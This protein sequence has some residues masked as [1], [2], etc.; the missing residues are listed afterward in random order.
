MYATGRDQDNF[1]R[2]YHDWESWQVH[3]RALEV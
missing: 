1:E 3:L 2:L